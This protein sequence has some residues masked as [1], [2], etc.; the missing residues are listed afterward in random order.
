MFSLGSQELF[1]A[2]EKDLPN[3]EGKVFVITGK[4]MICC[5]ILGYCWDS[6]SKK[7]TAMQLPL[8]GTTSGTGFIA[9]KAVAKHGGEVLLLNRPSSRSIA[10]LERLREAV[11]DGKFVPIDCDLQDFTSVRNAAAEIKSK[12]YTSI[13]C[14][15]NNAGIL[16]VPDEITKTD[17]FDKQIQTNYLSHF[18]LTRELFPLIVVGSKEHGDARIVQHSSASRHWTPKDCLEEKYF[19]EQDS[20]GLLGGNDVK[21]F[22]FGGPWYRYY[23]SKLAN[24]VFAQCLNDKVLAS[25]DDDIKNILSVCAHPGTCDTNLFDKHR[26]KNSLISRIAEPLVALSF[27]SPADGS[28]GLLRGMMDYRE[29]VVGGTVY[30]PK[31]YGSYFHNMKG[32]PVRNQL[33]P[34]ETDPK[35]KEMLWRT[36]EKAIGVSFHI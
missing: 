6:W 9:A 10:S 34:C 30:G 7:L 36:S 19:L 17:G 23:Q 28:M 24:S 4:S 14:L 22:V 11:P 15:A 25:E 29:N 26:P 31:L 20:D 3:V 27:Q 21:F 35:A 18:L 12:G 8:S 13:Y 33:M 16:A 32:P 2:F 1:P 5:V